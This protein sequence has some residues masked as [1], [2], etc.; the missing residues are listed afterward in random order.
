[1]SEAEML[2][3]T[4]FLDPLTPLEL[5]PKRSNAQSHK[6]RDPENTAAE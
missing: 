1:M 3:S 6:P 2:C 5:R 4:W